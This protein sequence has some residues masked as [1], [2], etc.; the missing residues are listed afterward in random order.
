MKDSCSV[1]NT[2]HGNTFAAFIFLWEL[3]Q[4]RTAHYST[5]NIIEYLRL[6]IQGLSLCGI[7]RLTR[8]PQ[9]TGLPSVRKGKSNN[10]LQLKLK[11]INGTKLV[12]CPKISCYLLY[13]RVVGYWAHLEIPISEFLRITMSNAIFSRIINCRVL[14]FHLS[15]WS[16]CFAHCD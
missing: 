16:S 11:Q 8:F 6:E 4:G 9:T 15:E 1:I 13:A 14:P 10:R 3:S 12:K 7:K 2:R 5:L